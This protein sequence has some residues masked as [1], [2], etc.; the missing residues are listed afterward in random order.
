MVENK[1]EKIQLKVRIAGDTMV[2][3]KWEKIHLKVRIADEIM[4]GK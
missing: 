2:E 3:N 1:W 4:V